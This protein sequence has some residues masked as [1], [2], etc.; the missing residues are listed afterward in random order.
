M[1]LLKSYQLHSAKCNERMNAA[2]IFIIIDRNSDTHTHPHMHAEREVSILQ[3]NDKITLW[4]DFL[5]KMAILSRMIIPN[6][7]NET[8]KFKP[9]FATHIET[10]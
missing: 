4:S 6:I 7:K 8:L 3:T 9:K 2:S 5:N 10:E 1:A